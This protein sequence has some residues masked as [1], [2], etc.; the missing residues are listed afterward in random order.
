[1]FPEDNIPLTDESHD[2]NQATS[3]CIALLR[4]GLQ[5]KETDERYF[6]TDAAKPD[7]NE[8][9][10]DYHAIGIEYRQTFLRYSMVELI[11]DVLGEPAREILPRYVTTKRA[12]TVTNPKYDTLIAYVNGRHNLWA[13][14]LAAP[15]QLADFAKI[16]DNIIMSESKAIVFDDA[17]KDILVEIMIAYMNT[18]QKVFVRTGPPLQD[19]VLLASD[20]D[21]GFSCKRTRIN[22]D[23]YLECAADLIDVLSNTY[24]EKPEKY[25]AKL[26]DMPRTKCHKSEGEN[27]VKSTPPVLTPAALA[28][29]THIFPNE[30]DDS[31]I[32]KHNRHLKTII[33]VGM[34]YLLFR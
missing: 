28:A 13:Q 34:H 15:P 8:Y 9:Y 17:C 25:V 26:S 33:R 10:S 27:A 23:N 12:I 3:L 1:M 18:G 20:P 32:S 21:T 11:I 19:E 22:L 30:E 24:G 16:K 4:I 5:G 6:D 7:K 29:I 31:I 2:S 14:K